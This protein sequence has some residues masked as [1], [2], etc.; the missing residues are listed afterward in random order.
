MDIEAGEVHDIL[1]MQ[2]SRIGDTL[3]ATPAL[4]TL[5]TAF[6]EARLTCLAHPNRVEILQGLQCIHHLGRITKKLAP[7]RG[8]LPGR[9][10]DLAVVFGFD[11]PLV[12][13]ALRVAHWVV[14]FRQGNPALDARLWRAVEEPA[15]QSRHAVDYQLALTDAIGLP[16]AGRHLSYVVSADER[17]WASIRLASLRT[18]SARPLIGLQVASFPTKGYRDWPVA[19]FIELCRCIRAEHCCA[20]FL[21]FGGRLE[22]ER[23][24]ALHAALEDCSTHY[25]GSLSLRQTAA[26]MN[27]AD[28][29]V[30]VDTGPTHI[31]GALHRPMVAMY[32]GYSP[33]RLLAPLEHPCLWTV[34][35][36]QAGQETSPDD[37]PMSDVSVDMVLAK[38]REALA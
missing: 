10:Y 13:Y 19:H 18:R 37:Y 2:V 33:S 8:W 9:N 25:A 26:L 38:V 15:F 1:V 27:E 34:D 24:Q 23:T 12:A 30:G 4:R 31:M 22:R 14:A 32:H 7:L 21:I 6:P 35:H 36:P 29:Y 11:Q 16:S 5:A 28:L 17:K 3:L 20:H